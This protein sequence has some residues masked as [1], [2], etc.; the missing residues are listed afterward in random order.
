MVYELQKASFW[1][2]LAAW[3]FDSI[4]VMILAVGIAF[5][6]SA[7]LGYDRHSDAVS[8][9]YSR[10]ETEYG[11]TF[12]VSREE[13]DGWPEEK[14]QAYD[15][16]YE[17]LL[18]DEEA[19]RS[20]NM[21]VN[22]TMLVASLSILAAFVGLELVVPLVLKNGRTLGKKIFSLCVVRTDCVRINGLQLFARTVLGKFAVETMIPVYLLLMLFWGIAGL[23][24]TLVIGVVLLVQLV[25]ILSSRRRPAIH[26]L[27]AGTAVADFAGQMIFADREELIE[28]QKKLHAERAARQDY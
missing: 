18:A 4:L 25:C 1:K 19:I 3:L 11:I 15:A 20:Y 28:Y 27:L 22:L 21:V 17:A 14:R 24:A 12:Q 5:L 23:G 9:A 16:A 6:L 10:Y 8:E 2:R 7:A 26:D 13:Y